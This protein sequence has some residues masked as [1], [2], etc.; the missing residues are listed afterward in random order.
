MKKIVRN[1]F[2]IS[3]IFF[4]GSCEDSDKVFD[5]VTSDVTRG[6]VLRTVNLIS[7]E[8]PIGIADAGFSAQLEVQE[9]TDDNGEV[10]SVEVYV[11]FNDNTVEAGANDLDVAEGLIATLPASDFTI[12]EFGLPRFDYSISLTEM[13]AFTG[14]NELDLFG[15]DQFTVRFELVMSDGRRFTNTDNSG[16]LTGN[17][18]SS[19]F[20]Y[21][22][23]V[24]CFVGAE[25]FIGDYSVTQ[26]VP[27]IFA[28]N[29]WG[30]GTTV[31]LSVGETSVQRVFEAVYLPEFGIGNGPRAFA[32]DLICGNIDV[33]SGQASGLQCVGG[34]TFGPPEA[35]RGTYSV[36]ATLIADDDSSF[37][38][39]FRD[40]ESDDCGGGV[41]AEVQLT[42]L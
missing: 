22:P 3:S 18:F 4:I 24:V 28:S 40:D 38:I 39:V 35:T 12:G 41:D 20:L 9:Q 21:T 23:T 42:K 37:N 17:F 31:T 10:T 27:G 32:F 25:Q 30:N 5:Q 15:G 34:I 33:P 1:L 6:A 7:N 26:V 11:G 16:T 29:T 8:L 19:P 36:D 13:L 2:A 14:V